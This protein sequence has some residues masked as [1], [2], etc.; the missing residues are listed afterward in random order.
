MTTDKIYTGQIVWVKPSGLYRS[1][2][3]P[4]EATVSKVGRKYFELLEHNRSKFRIDDLK[5][6]TDTNYAAI[7]YLTHQD[8]LDEDEHAK[9]SETVRASFQSYGILPYSLDQLRKIIEIIKPNL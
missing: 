5:Q 2:R 8:I 1:K 3:E 6:E 4:Y 7:V 9:L